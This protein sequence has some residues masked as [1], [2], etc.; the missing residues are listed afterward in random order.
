MDLMRRAGKLPPTRV[1]QRRFGLGI[2]VEW[3]W[4]GSFLC[5]V[6]TFFYECSLEHNCELYPHCAR[7][8]ILGEV[9]K[10]GRIHQG[11]DHVF[12]S[13][14]PLRIESIGRRIAFFDGSLQFDFDL[15]GSRMEMV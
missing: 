7:F 8:H 1:Q 12:H 2:L 10:L 14:S 11:P 5:S 13:L 3:L 6:R 4:A 9:D 15:I